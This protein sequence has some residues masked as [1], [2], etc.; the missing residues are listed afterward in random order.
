MKKEEEEEDGNDGE[1]NA[2]VRGEDRARGWGKTEDGSNMKSI[3]RSLTGG[4]WALA[5]CGAIGSGTGGPCCA[6]PAFGAA[7]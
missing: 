7:L 5:H 2:S 3:A 1:G 4:C 6:S